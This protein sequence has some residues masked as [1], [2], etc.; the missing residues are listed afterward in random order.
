MNTKRAKEFL[1]KTKDLKY[2]EFFEAFEAL[3]GPLQEAVQNERYSLKRKTV[4][5]YFQAS[6]AFKEKAQIIL[7]PSGKYRLVI[8]PFK[9]TEKGWNYSQ[10]EVFEGNRPITIVRRNY[11]SFPYCW[12]EA[13]ANGHDYLIAGEDYQGQTVV[14]L[15]SGKRVDHIP[16]GAIQGCGFCWAE[17]RYDPILQML[18][19]TGCFWACP[20]EYRFYDFS[21]PMSG[22]PELETGQ[23]IDDSTSWPR[24]QE[25]GTI[26]T[27]QDSWDDDEDEDEDDSWDDDEDEEDDENL[28]KERKPAAT[29]TFK[30][31][32]YRLVLQEEWIADAERERRAK[33]E[34]AQQE[35]SQWLKDFRATDPLYLKARELMQDPVLTPEKHEGIGITYQGWCPSF[36]KEE[37]RICHRIV[38]RDSDMP[39]YIIDLEWGADTGPIKIIVYKDGKHTEDR[40]FEHSVVGM[41]QVFDYARA[42]LSLVDDTG[43]SAYP[44]A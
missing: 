31:V 11:S 14:E 8:T 6:K 36:D 26:L 23:V 5:E 20:Y 39:G 40:F 7:S 3:D 13:H 37:R 32:G 16:A 43:P 17:Y 1:E 9:T 19:V 44:R 34:K 29:Q 27:F 25:D 22:W 30:R 42:L 18:I 10:G 28:Q 33:A 41:E 12:V 4:E 38:K 2:G 24:V 35:Y 15:D 21:D